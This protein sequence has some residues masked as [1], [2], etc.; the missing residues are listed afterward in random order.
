MNCQAEQI[1]R[2]TWMENNVTAWNLPQDAV[3]KLATLSSPG[4]ASIQLCPAVQ[5][6]V[7]PSTC[8]SILPRS[9][10][11]PVCLTQHCPNLSVCPSITSVPLLSNCSDSIPLSVHLASVPALSNIPSHRLPICLASVPTLSSIPPCHPPNYPAI[12]LIL[13]RISPALP[14]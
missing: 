1:K 6:F 5:P 12:C 14:R 4:L 2:H 9:C 11:L 7:L 8:L 13:S 3:R 10:R